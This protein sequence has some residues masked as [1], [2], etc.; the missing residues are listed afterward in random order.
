MALLQALLEKHAPHD[1]LSLLASIWLRK[2]EPVACSV[3]ALDMAKQLITFS[4]GQSVE[5]Q[6][7]FPP[8]LLALA[9]QEASVRKAA[10]DCLLEVQ[11]TYEGKS[12]KKKSHLKLFGIDTFYG[13]QAKDSVLFLTT[14]DASQFINDVAQEQSSFLSDKHH[15]QEWITQYF[16][17][18]KK[19]E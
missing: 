16:K 18:N 17:K 8:L 5:F 9:H 10:V 3:L 15:L 6:I 4:K 12:T 13:P 14:G 19:L 7:L 1:L 11:K 2:E